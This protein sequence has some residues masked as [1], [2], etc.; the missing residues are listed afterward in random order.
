MREYWQ[1]KQSLVEG[2]GEESIQQVLMDQSQAQD[3]TTETEPG[4]VHTHTHTRTHI[5]KH[6]NPE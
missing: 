1:S 6:Y 5:I 4:H 3:T 2:S